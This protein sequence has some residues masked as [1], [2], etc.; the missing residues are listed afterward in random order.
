M[1]HLCQTT[2]RPLHSATLTQG[3]Q[4]ATHRSLFYSMGWLPDNLNKPLVA[5]VNSF[6]ELVPGHVHMQPLCQ[7]I[8]LGIAEAGGT[9]LE[10]PSIAVCD[11]LATG[12]DGMRMPMPS[13]ELIADSIELMITA[14]A[15]DAMVLLT[16]CDKITPGMLMAAARLNIPSIVVTGGPMDTGCFRGRR[17][18]Y[19]DLIEAEAAVTRGLMSE[20]ELEE[21]EHTANPGPG[22][23]AMMGTANTMTILAEALGMTLTDS[24]LIPSHFGAR[25][26]L[27]RASGHAIIELHRQGI[28]P[29]DILTTKAFENALAVDMAI[30]GSTNTTLHL[31]AIAREAGLSLTWDDF[32]R[33]A[34]HTPHLAL[35]KPAGSY[36]ARDL[37]DAGGVAAVMNELG[38]HGRIH[39]DCM[40]ATGRTMGENIADRSICDSEIIH[41]FES[42]LSPEAAWPSCTATWRRKAPSSRVRPWRRR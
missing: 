1:I 6:N 20:Q 14:H 17:A 29:R 25:V 42:P 22:S 38:Q 30:G 35:I 5:V 11:G 16:N 40:T 7:A 32:T 3:T 26:A 18:C 4:R 21:F 27:A 34:E 33:V 37:Y 8:K 31:P 15:L 41:P 2:D 24:A 28:L 10:F 23:C 19:T 12:M 9:P 39:L 13:R 36:F